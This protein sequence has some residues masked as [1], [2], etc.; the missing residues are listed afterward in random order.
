MKRSNKFSP[1]IRERAVRM[2]QEHLKDYSSHWVLEGEPTVTDGIT[3]AWFAF[4]TLVSRGKGLLRL[5]RSFWVRHRIK[6][7]YLQHRSITA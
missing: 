5:W 6:K 2:V 7:L 1:E 4:E 3:E